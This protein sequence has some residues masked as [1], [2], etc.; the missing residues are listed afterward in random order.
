M[1]YACSAVRH[2]RARYRHAVIC[3]DCGA[4]TRRGE[5]SGIWLDAWSPP[6]AEQV[7]ALKYRSGEHWE[8]Q[9]GPSEDLREMRRACDAADLHETLRREEAA[10]SAML[11]M[12][13]K[14]IAAEGPEKLRRAHAERL[15]AISARFADAQTDTQTAKEESA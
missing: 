4:F 13:P 7:S 8:I 1:L 6:L 11:A 3:R 15:E 5:V 14:D 9:A 10:Y 12:L 2:D